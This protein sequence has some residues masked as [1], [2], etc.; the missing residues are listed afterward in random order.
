MLS[1]LRVATAARRA[2]GQAAADIWLAPLVLASTRGAI[3][4][5]DPSI[6]GVTST[7]YMPGS[8]LFPVRDAIAA[9]PPTDD[10][11]TTTPHIHTTIHLDLDS[12]TLDNI[13]QAH[14]LDQDTAEFNDAGM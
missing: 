1:E 12:D 9:D 13:Q 14:D 10:N 7:S 6:S 2:L 4:Q 11:R 5:V 3:D 8:T